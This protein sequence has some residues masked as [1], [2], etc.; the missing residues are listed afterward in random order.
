M[1]TYIKSLPAGA[2]TGPPPGKELIAAGEGIYRDRCAKCH[3]DSG[4]GG[5]F[6]GPPLFGS[7]VV[8]AISPASLINAI[9][10]GATP[11]EGIKLGAWETMKPYAD[12]LS[13]ADIAAVANFV[14]GTWG[15][16]APVVDAAAVA[17]Q[18]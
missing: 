9:L 11:P 6:Q 5:M 14:R 18:R 3:G 16:E 15:N 13:D 2:E 17:K 1:A 10:Y 7:A 8:R 12:I 4:R